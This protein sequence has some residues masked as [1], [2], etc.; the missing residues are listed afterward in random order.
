[1]ASTNFPGE[2]VYDDGTCAICIGPHENKSRPPCGHVFCFQCLAEW[3]RIRLKCP[4]C[5]RRITSFK[6]SFDS[7]NNFQVHQCA[8]TINERRQQ[9]IRFDERRRRIL[10]FILFTLSHSTWGLYV[11]NTML[12]GLGFIS[13]SQLSFYHLIISC[14]SLLIFM[15]YCCCMLWTLNE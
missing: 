5:N 3:C 10:D 13:F 7:E 2:A 12:W 14:C 11:T 8:P 15:I 9:R 1:M 6:H 4:M